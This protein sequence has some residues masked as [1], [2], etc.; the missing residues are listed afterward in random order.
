MHLASGGSSV[1]GHGLPEL[2]AMY[3]NACIIKAPELARQCNT[4]AI[5]IN[6]DNLYD[7]Y[8]L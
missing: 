6:N 1:L 8:Y 7:V 3:I 5:A 4:V 2:A